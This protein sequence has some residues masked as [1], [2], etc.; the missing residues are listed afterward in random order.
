M[1]ETKQKKLLLLD[2][3]AI[4]HRAYHGL[5]DFT[6][7]SGEPTGALYGYI[8]FLLKAVKDYQPDY[9]VAAFDLPGPTFRHDQY[10]EYKGTRQKIDD[11]LISQLKAARAVAEALGIVVYE[12][13]GFEADDMLGTVVKELHGRKDIDILIASGD[14]DTLQLVNDEKVRVYTLK[15][16]INDT[17][18][19]NEKAVV[20]RFGFV[21]KLLP[22]YKGLRGDMSDNIVGVKGIGEKTAEQLIQ[23]FGTL[24]NILEIAKEHPDD[25]REAGVKDRIIGLLKT[26]EEEALFSKM[27]AT[28]RDDAP[29]NFKLPE[30]TWREGVD[31]N[32][33]EEMCKQYSFRTLAGR[34]REAVA[35][36]E[37]WSTKH[38]AQDNAVKPTHAPRSTLHASEF[39]KLQIMAWLVDSNAT[40]PEF[41]K[42]L[43]IAGTTDIPSAEALLMA[44]IKAAKLE[45][46]LNDIELPLIPIIDAADAYGILID[47]KKLEDLSEEYHIH[48]ARLEREIH[49]LAGKEFNINSPK[50]LGEI[51]FDE[52][53][54]EVKGLKKTAGGARSTRESELDKLKDMHPI[55]NKILEYREY[56]K[57]LS[58][59][60]DAIPKLVDKEGRLHTTLIQAGSATGRMASKNPGLQ[61]IPIKTDLG[62]AI[63][64]AFVAPRGSEL[65][66]FDYSQIELRVAAALSGDEKL[67]KIFND[68]G[69]VHASVASLVF[70]V[71]ADEVDREM[72]RR[73]KVINFGI[74][75]GMGVH[76][77]K[78]NLGT[79]REEAQQ[80]Y[81]AYFAQFKQL[82][83]YLDKVL[84]DARRLGYTTTYYG[85]RRY[86][87]N[88][89]SRMP[90][91]KAMEERMAGN[92]P[93]QGTATGDIIKLAMIKADAEIR[94]AHLDNDAKLLLQV[95][96]ELIYE[97][98]KERVK[99]AAEVIKKAMESAS[100]IAVPITVNASHG[101]SW[102]NL[103]A[104]DI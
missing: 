70:G 86:F 37:A 58:T 8:T 57:L 18:I 95:H 62:R 12:L 54:L 84:V 29:I 34:L 55:V 35:G 98:K 64:E 22:D 14:M 24:E 3:H 20:A 94:K 23:K 72:R 85:R 97:V 67:L 68:G 42:V 1:Q 32:Q 45:N 5:P 101:P 6:S 17:V 73:A 65:L 19:Y 60:I 99:E 52:L 96:D 89:N 7:D 75:Y 76:A 2:S 82:S 15:K 38:V 90:Q 87:K 48:T 31:M 47:K 46:V 39:K 53:K 66:A 21:P 43:Q 92:A 9:V 102:G 61:N 59:Y 88:I 28:I 50:Q 93:I 49:D 51:L 33:V 16:G 100:D 10:K 103:R 41:D 80:F 63:R 79:T 56:Q 25:M 36:G 44:K 74:I 81:D 83:D 13:P 71:P 4:L 77:L 27:L 40:D 30:K 69:D 11:D 91:L 78:Q 26:N 104:L